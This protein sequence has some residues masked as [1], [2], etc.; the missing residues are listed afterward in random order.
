MPEPRLLDTFTSHTFLR[1]LGERYQMT[2][3]S[4]AQPFK[5][6]PGQMLAKEGEDANKFFLIQSGHVSLGITKSGSGVVPVHTVGPGEVVGWSWLVPP[7]RWKFECR[8]VDEASGIAFDAEWLREKCE[9]DHELGYQL[10][11]ELLAV[12]SDRLT[13]TRQ[14][15]LKSL[16]Q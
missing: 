15:L 5:A 13:D 1:A 11:K 12:V 7:H 14:E 4:G 9:H 16:K 10:T 8:A 3:A 2:L 6:K